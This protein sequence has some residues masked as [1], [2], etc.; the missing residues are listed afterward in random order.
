MQ[1]LIDIPEKEYEKWQTDGEIDA[2]VVRDA[3]INC[4]PLP[5]RRGRLIDA[6][7]MAAQA[8]A[9]FLKEQDNTAGELEKT[10]NEIIYKKIQE[11]IKK[12]PAIEI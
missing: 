9:R 2:L 1:I 3:L 6:D 5:R 8:A 10:I 7:E 4:A 11:L 12:A